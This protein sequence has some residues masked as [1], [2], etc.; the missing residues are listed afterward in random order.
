MRRSGPTKL[1][2]GLLDALTDPARR[3]RTAVAVL[4][5]YVALWTLYGTLAKASQDINSDMSE[6]YVLSRELAWGYPK[7][8]PFAMVV[9]RA[10]FAVFPTAEWA[11]YLLAV[12]TAGL[13]LWIAWRLSARFL[14]GE[15]RV[16]GLALLTLVPF[17]NFHAL[18]FNQNSVLMPLWAA[19]TL[20]F[21]RSFETRRVLDAALAGLGAAAC[22]YGKYW[23]IFLLLGLG[24]AALLDRRRAAYFRSGAPWVTIA[25]G[26][27]ALAPHAAWLVAND[28]VPFSYA[29]AGHGSTS[30]VSAL[31]GALGYLAGGVAYVAVPL[32]LVFVAA[33]PSRPVLQDMAWPPPPERRLAALA[34]WATL[35]LPPVIAILTWIRLNS[36]WT[37]SAW[38]L[39]PVML[40]SSPLVAIGRRDAVR[41][42]ALA[43]LLPFVMVALAPAIAF[44]I[45]RAGPAPDAALSS[46][47]VEPIEQLWRKTTDRPLKVFAGY[48]DFTDGV[49]FYMRSHPLAAHVLDG[50]ISPAMGQRIGRDGIA[51]LCPASPR[52]PSSAANCMNAATSLMARFPLGKQQEIEVSRRYLGFDGAPA[53]YLLFAIPPRQP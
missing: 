31:R 44:G 39:L 20:W 22:M 30:L 32:V 24:I 5:G 27:L 19:T 16:V 33:R 38:T 26:A 34:F 9:V 37:M 29:V 1:V 42:L 21:L 41:V 12:A 36:L 7:H 2:E 25:A 28:F 8:P 15:K 23:S 6:Q 50:P 51:L 45:H 47:L 46:V 52:D 14:D 13:A 43:V 17:F 40:L 35:L 49:A 3:E 4:L 48:D 18:K 11:F 10:W 53:R